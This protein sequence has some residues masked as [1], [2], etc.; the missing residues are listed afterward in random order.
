MPGGL[1]TKAHMLGSQRN[2]AAANRLALTSIGLA[3]LPLALLG[4]I[5]PALAHTGLEH[6]FSFASGFAHPCTGLDHMLALVAVGLWAGLN[7]GRAIWAWPAAFLVAMLS[8]GALG[9]AGVFVPLAEPGIL[10]SLLVL[11][12]LVLTA[13]RLPLALGA[14]LIAL[15]AIAHGHAHGAELPNTAAA[16]TYVAGFALATALLHAAGIALAR[17][18]GSGYGSLLV[19]GAGAAVAAVGVALTVS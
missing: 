6:A 12:L 1:P 4:A 14:A 13:A 11:G 18:G 5:D 10:A 3:P 8:G 19:R 7:G 9:I 2:F 16:V 17:A 15:F